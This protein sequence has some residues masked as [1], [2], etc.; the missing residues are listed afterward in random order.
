MSLKDLIKK[1]IKQLGSNTKYD[2]KIVVMPH[3]CV[4]VFVEVNRNYLNFQKDLKKVVERGGGNIRISQKVYRGGKAANLASALSAFG[5]NTYLIARTD[6]FGYKMLHSFFKDTN[7]DISHVSKEGKFSIT[8]ALELKDANIMLSDPGSLEEF[9]PLMLHDKDVDL[10]KSADI[11][12]ISDWGLNTKGTDLVKFVFEKVKYSGKGKTFFDPG[13][14]S[15]KGEK[16]EQEITKFLDQ[17]VAQGLVDIFSVNDDELLKFGRSNDIAKAI[18]NLKNIKRIDLHTKKSSIS[19][20]KEKKAKKIPSV[21]ITPRRLTG[22]GDSWNA[23]NILG[24]IFGVDDD[25]RLLLAN[26]VAAFYIS[27][28]EAKHPSRS[29]LIKF[30]E[31]NYPKI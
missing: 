24:E 10:I 7:V 13:D 17:V 4:D 8:T 15:S 21:N 28:T 19:Y 11:I 14:P 18:Q 5:L 3:F 27:N 6:D 29:E 20:Y 26:S 1:L 2:N 16:E 31:N 12:C 22:A 9:G 25:M 23:G 30:L